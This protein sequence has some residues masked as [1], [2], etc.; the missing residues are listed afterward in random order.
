MIDWVTAI[1]PCSNLDNIQLHDGWFCRVKASGEKEWEKEIGISIPGSHDSSIRISRDSYSGFSH[2]RIDG[3]P[4]K[5]LQGHNIFGSNDLIGL[6]NS[7]MKRLTEIIPLNP[8]LTNRVA[9][10]EGCYLL[11]RVDCTEMWE[12]PSLKDVLTWLNVAQHQAKSRHGRPIM[13]GGTLYFGKNSRRWAFKFY[14]KGEEI[15]VKNHTLPSTLPLL[16]KLNTFAGNKLRGEL[17]LRK[18]MLEK[19]NYHYAGNWTEETS[20]YFFNHYLKKIEFSDQFKLTNRVIDGLKP[21]L[22]LAYNSWIEGHDLKS[23]LPK[24]TFYRYRREML[25]FGI[26]ISV[27]KKN[28]RTRPIQLKDVVHSEPIQIP[29]WA[30]GT[31][32]YF[33]PEKLPERNVEIAV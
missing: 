14:S 26:D 25:A 20:S 7:L 24:N 23:I 18:P 6:V 27:S 28:E 5:W 4:A 8:S 13:T 11:K 9:W 32:I 10:A 21:R 30:L 17:V 12:L 29:Q 1:V 33:V 15:R 31:D 16:E 22:N 2:L 3:N 19:Q